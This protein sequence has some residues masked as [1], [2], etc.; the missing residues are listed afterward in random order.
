MVLCFVLALAVSFLGYGLSRRVLGAE[1]GWEALTLA[2]LVGS[3]LLIAGANVV[4]PVEIRL[5]MTI[6]SALV[7]LA[8]CWK[9]RSAS[10]EAE[11][12]AEPSSR[13]WLGTLVGLLVLVVGYVIYAGFF[14]LDTDNW[15][16][17]PLIATYAA[18]LFPPQHP[19]F[20]GVE[21]KGHYGRDLLIA[22]LLPPKTDPLAVVW[23]LNPVLALASAG[24]LLTIAR[25]WGDSRSSALSAVAMVF[26]GIC[27]GFRVGL[28][29]CF[30]GNNGVVYALAIA[31]FYVMLRVFGLL[32]SRRPPP[33][34]ALGVLAG[35]L[36]GTYCLVYETHFALFLL[37]GAVL[38]VPAIWRSSERP[39]LVLGIVLTIVV[40]LG[41]SAVEG[42]PITDIVQ[43]KMS[44]RKA[45]ETL[46]EANVAQH[47]TMKFP[48][49]QLFK[50]LATSADYMR[51][52]P[53]FRLGPF[54][55][56]T[57]ETDTEG[58][59]SIFSPSFL[60]THWLPVFSAPLTLLWLV[61]RR[62]YPGLAF[63]LF[64]AWAYLVPSLIDFGPTYEL[65]YFRWEFAAGFGFSVPLG[66]LCGELLS[67][68]I[69]DPKRRRATRL[70]A[71][72]LLGLAL[73][74]AEKMIN[75]AIIDVQKNGLPPIVPPGD[76][77]VARPELG[78]TKA[79]IACAQALSGKVTPGEFMMTNLGSESPL[80]LWPDCVISGL[81]A[82]RIGG[83]A[84]PPEGTRLHA[85]PLFYRSSLQKALMA[86]SRLDLLEQ[87][88]VPWLVL[89]PSRTELDEKLAE[90][91]QAK[92]EFE[93]TIGGATRQLWRWTSKA[94]E[95]QPADPALKVTASLSGSGPPE[96][97]AV[98]EWRSNTLMTLELRV[99]NPTDKPVS[100]GWVRLRV[101]GE[102]G[103]E[104]TEPLN[105]RF[106]QATLAPGAEMSEPLP[107]V[108]PLGEGE[109]QVIVELP[110]GGEKAIEVARLPLRLSLLER[111]GELKGA[112][113]V[114]GAL[115]PKRFAPLKLTLSSR[116]ALR[117]RGELE[118]RVRYRQ[119]G[120][121]YV[122][123][124]DRL[125]IPLALDIPAAGSQVV[126]WDVVTPWR[127][128]TFLLEL[129]IFDCGTGYSVPI[130]M[131]ESRLTVSS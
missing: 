53:G 69:E 82:A 101:E 129:E 39:R 40:S 25:R 79:D 119:D 54:R 112:L 99:T 16:H 8:L 126:E 47:V 88:Q 19:F 32:P 122:W 113:E 1:D 48:K 80:G 45:P 27:V 73:W 60:A 116:E 84:H 22:S 83:R 21:L 30:D 20:A 110:S 103:R 100:T 46:Q 120:G 115:P 64:G 72:V 70:A 66:L 123:E 63:W 34:V 28:A 89:D 125:A 76:W 26:F 107:F 42:G 29:D 91:S 77:R 61:R 52:S 97:E 38:L 56:L 67:R 57:P 18:G 35:V 94:A 15:V 5:P 6:G 2:P 90:S 65:E 118:L 111:L 13:T 49:S 55:S 14:T 10:V 108:T 87:A 128:G 59:I 11:V 7:G 50:V 95:S 68:S 96:L 41:L 92:K 105:Y 117:S 43:A 81:S 31:L 36:L 37:T 85:H 24:V 33:R 114:P 62:H 104:V 78:V 102:D 74:P 23:L 86:S 71:V 9:G 58:Y 106:H 17:E 130:K 51:V 131:P 93:T 124:L 121:D 12:D 98:R 3:L 127:P 44:G 4:G 75:R 109:F